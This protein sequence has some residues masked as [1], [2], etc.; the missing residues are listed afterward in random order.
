[1][2]A[3]RR[4]AAAAALVLGAVSLASVAAA[5]TAGKIPTVGVVTFQLASELGAGR[6]DSFRHE[7]GQR[8]WIEGRTIA[9]E[10]R[11]ADGNA[12]RLDR[13][14]SDMVRRQVDVVVAPDTRASAVAARA[15]KT[16]PV[17]MWTSADPV[18]AGIVASLARPGGNV[19]GLADFASLS[20]KL[21]ELLKQVA[22]RISRVGVL[23]NPGGPQGVEHLRAMEE[24]ARALGLTLQVVDARGLADLEGAFAAMVR[25]RSDALTVL[26][27]SVFNAAPIRARLAALALKHRLPMIYS[28]RETTEAGGLLSYGIDRSFVFRQQ[29]RYV[30]RILKGAKPAELPVEQPTQFDLVI[31]L[32]TAKALG[33]TVPPALLLRSDQVIE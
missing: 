20:S 10:F 21:L 12:E 33:L 30:D 15:T 23:R 1:V 9:L 2:P 16:I 8:G 22:P 7:L 28:R 14:M 17:V 19:T 3:T 6:Y 11:F 26:V 25:E 13:L 18:K 27:D 24:A 31:N 5:Q 29:A 32:R 4:L